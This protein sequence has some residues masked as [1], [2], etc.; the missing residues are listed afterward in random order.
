LVAPVSVPALALPDAPAASGKQD[1]RKQPDQHQ[2]Q[3]QKQQQQAKKQQNQLD[4][5]KKEQ[6]PVAQPST[7][8]EKQKKSQKTQQ[9]PVPN[10]AAAPS[11]QAHNVTAASAAPTPARAPLLQSGARDTA[12]ASA[13]AALVRRALT[14]LPPRTPPRL[15]AALP[16]EHMTMLN[17]VLESI[18]V[19]QQALHGLLPLL[20]PGFDLS[21]PA[22]VPVAS[23]P[24]TAVPS[25]AAH[26]TAGAQKKRQRQEV[27]LLAG[28]PLPKKPRMD[29]GAAAA[30][31][32]GNAVTAVAVSS[33][34][35]PQQD[36]QPSA[37][38]RKQKKQKQQQNAT[39]AAS[40]IPLSTASTPAVDTLTVPM[41]TAAASGDAAV[42]LSGKKRERS[43]GATPAPDAII[44][45][46]NNASGVASNPPSAK[47]PRWGAEKLL[48]RAQQNATPLATAS[49]LSTSTPNGGAAA[50]VQASGSKK[51][52][53]SKKE[54]LRRQSVPA[55]TKTTGTPAAAAAT[56]FAKAAGASASTLPP[57]GSVTA[58]VSIIPGATRSAVPIASPAQRLNMGA[59]PIAVPIQRP[60][61]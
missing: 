46:E 54:L 22:N 42:V 53:P 14:P 41:P 7:Q 10:P 8:A 40:D 24:P 52:R 61:T 35:Q 23:A 12:A 4:Q 49:N 18:R 45:V 25:G 21:T 30:V 44:A 5:Q 33:Q 43:E 1:T 3:Q 26:A 29:V 34:P 60:S 50:I 48:A 55:V 51:K 57:F 9:A 47:K 59:T 13:T 32:A 11:K 37:K 17:A 58:A 16:V 27:A 19:Q 15:E 39:P 31:S 6:K 36:H 28:A 56:P 20:L 38:K 2:S